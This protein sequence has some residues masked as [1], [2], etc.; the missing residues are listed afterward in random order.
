MGVD[1]TRRRL[2]FGASAFALLAQVPVGFALPRR[3]AKASAL[4]DALIARMSVEEKAGQLT[5]SGSAQQTD[6]A[7]AANPINAVPTAEANLQRRAPGG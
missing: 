7:A 3:A 6:A 5:L 2:L 1:T 4:I